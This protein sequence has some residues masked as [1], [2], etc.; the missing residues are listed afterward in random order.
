MRSLLSRYVGPERACFLYHW[1]PLV[2]QMRGPGFGDSAHVGHLLVEMHT[3]S[4]PTG[5]PLPTVTAG[6]RERGN[7][8]LSIFFLVAAASLECV[9]SWIL[10]LGD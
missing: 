7:S 2:D 5:P 8:G 6:P 10:L 4:I 1:L 3:D 9:H